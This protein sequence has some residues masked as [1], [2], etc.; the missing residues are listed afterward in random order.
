VYATVVTLGLLLPSAAGGLGLVSAHRAVKGLAQEVGQRAGSG[1]ILALEGPIE[2]AGAL[3]WYSGHRP[4]IVEGR[5]SVL[6]F[7]ATRPPAEG[8]FWDAERLTRAWT[9]PDRVWLVTGRPPERSVVARLPAAHLVAVGGGRRL[10][11]NR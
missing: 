2:N 7:G 4:V 8:R 9:S 3:E 1:D 10:Y 6:G 11:V 5:R